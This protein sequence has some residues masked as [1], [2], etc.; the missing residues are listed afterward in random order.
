MRAKTVATILLAAI[1]FLAGRTAGGTIAYFTSTQNVAGNTL[2]AAS[3]FAP[4]GLA[5]ALASGGSVA[6]SWTA[7]AG[8]W[9]TGYR[10]FRATTSGGY[11]FNAPLSSGSCAAPVSGTSCTDTPGGGGT[12]FYV[13]RAISGRGGSAVSSN[14]A[15]IVIGVVVITPSAP[16]STT[17]ATYDISGTAPSN[18]CVRVY[19][20]ANNDGVI[21]GTDA[22]VSSVQLS[23]G[24]SGWSANVPLALPGATPSINN[25]LVTAT[26][27]SSFNPGCTSFGGAESTPA[28]VPTITRVSSTNATTIGQAT[29]RQA[30]DTSVDITAAFTGDGNANNSATYAVACIVGSGCTG[31]FGAEI[32]MARGSGQ[33]TA[34]AGGLTTGNTYRFRV[35][36]TDP[37][38][39]VG[40][41]PQF[42]TTILNLG[43][44]GATAITINSLTPNP[45]APAAQQVLTVA[46]DPGSASKDTVVEALTNSGTLVKTV[47]A[48]AARAKAQTA[49]W[50]G[51]NNSNAQ[52]PNGD[53]TLRIGR[54]TSTDGS[55]SGA[56]AGQTSATVEISNPQSI[57]M[58]PSPSTVTIT[59]G[60]CTGVHA[61][62][63]NSRN[64]P[65]AA[66]A[67]LVVNWSFTSSPAGQPGSFTTSNS[68][69]N[70]GTAT[71]TTTTG[72]GGISPPSGSPFFFRPGASTM[73]TFIITATSGGVS[74]STTINDPPPEPPQNV[75]LSLGSL[76]INW[77]PSSSPNAAG[78]LVF[79]GTRS[80][81]H[82]RVPFGS[83]A[84]Q[85]K[86][87]M[88]GT[89]DLVAEVGD[90]REHVQPDVVPGTTYYVAVAAYSRG[91]VLGR[92]STEASLTIPAVA[93]T[94][95]PTPTSTATTTPTTSVTPTPK[96][97]APSTSTATATATAT[98]T[99]TPTATATPTILPAPLRAGKYEDDHPAI[100]YTGPWETHSATE[101]S[102]G[103]Y[104]LSAGHDS[105]AE[106]PF[107]GRSIAIVSSCGPE[108]GRLRAL[109]DGRLAATIDQKSSTACWR[110]EAP[111][112][113]G[114]SGVH[115]LR[116]EA[117][118]DR[119]VTL[120]ALTVS[121]QPAAT[122]T[123]TI[124]PIP[125]GTLGAYLATVT[126]TPTPT[127]DGSVSPTGNPT[128]TATP[129]PITAAVVTTSPTATAT[130]SPSPTPTSTNTPSPTLTPTA[131]PT[132]TPTSS[133]KATPGTSPAPK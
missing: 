10:V 98:P 106:V 24:L 36:N 17:A 48:C 63:Y 91:G 20:D 110:R 50:D 120:D 126:A 5:A 46:Y 47:A 119:P 40:D 124:T 132:G 54:F 49:T 88:V 77:T 9:A 44:F 133:P 60:T 64:Q 42:T 13:V 71:T 113:A 27:V 95:T 89:T 11:D 45:F 114:A 18:T 97:P 68:P 28:D 85:V 6:L 55:C 65:V 125:A 107:D 70:P 79:V 34:T 16:V 115:L 128:P 82:D 92:P 99:V 62:I 87:I 103:K 102:G 73:T 61:T 66:G 130:L 111:L 43:G 56:N 101:A 14:E 129:T 1:L 108:L 19:S 105:A 131:T 51:S 21:N 118:G 100:R 86:E 57:V 72:A 69:C 38:G 37:D 122:A 41:N 3:A 78:Y 112:D 30:S 4:S 93:A 104:H 33:F 121:D 8:G 15:S 39:V 35:T 12:F 84:N 127:A 76:K 75:A 80:G 83:R 23:G 52:Q 2:G 96:P 67:G 25:F 59:A 32:S 31:A 123:P 117:E 26:S 7:P 58:F 116:V 22:V 81:V 94:P 74:G 29:S 53:Y 90:V 109:L